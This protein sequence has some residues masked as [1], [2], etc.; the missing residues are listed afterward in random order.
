MEW[1]SVDDRLPEEYTYVA[2]QLLNGSC[3]VDIANYGQL[4][5]YSQCDITHWMPLP[6]PPQPEN[7]E[8][9]DDQI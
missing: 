7:K 3:D 9:Q 2:V 6:E 1:I 4:G 8:K 5:F